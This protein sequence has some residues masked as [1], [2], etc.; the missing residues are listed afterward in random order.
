M[1]HVQASL[2]IEIRYLKVALFAC[3][4]KADEYAQLGA[5]DH[6]SLANRTD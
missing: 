4:Q 3:Q 6:L 2:Q 1:A 5:F